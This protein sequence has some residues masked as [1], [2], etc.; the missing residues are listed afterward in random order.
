M[1]AALAVE[2]ES[3][4]PQRPTMVAARDELNATH[5]A[6]GP[7]RPPPSTL[8]EQ[9]RGRF[10]LCCA[11]VFLGRFDCNTGPRTTAHWDRAIGIILQG[12]SHVEVDR[13]LTLQFERAYTARDAG[14]N[15]EALVWYDKVIANA[16]R[17]SA[18]TSAHWK[19]FIANKIVPQAQQ[20][21][22]E[23]ESRLGPS[24]RAQGCAQQ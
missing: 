14:D 19:A 8:A 2:V 20:L 13:Y 21:R 15:R 7:Q 11:H 16:N 10:A 1:P 22:F 6:L 17:A 4:G 9:H 18:T 23:Q 12:I 5:G 3:L 24:G